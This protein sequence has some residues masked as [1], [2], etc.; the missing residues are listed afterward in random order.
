M[1]VPSEG[2]RYGASVKKIAARL[3]W[4]GSLQRSAMVPKIGKYVFFKKQQ[5]TYLLPWRMVQNYTFL[6]EIS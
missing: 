5:D 3:M 6:Q 4:T 2:P 1:S